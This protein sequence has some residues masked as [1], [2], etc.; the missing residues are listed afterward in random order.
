MH[1]PVCCAALD[2]APQCRR[3]RADLTLLRRLE[4]E[5]CRLL[6]EARSRLVIQSTETTPALDVAER[7]HR[8]RPDT[9]SRRLLAI[10]HLLGRDFAK[11]WHYYQE[12]RLPTGNA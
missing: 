7:A 11:A 8:L 3:C 9:E 5:R 6:A 12:Q 1:C 4:E 2:S 10:S